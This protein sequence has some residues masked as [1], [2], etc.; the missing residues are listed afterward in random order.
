M[1]PGIDV[2]HWQSDIDWKKVAEAGVKFA[3][4]KASEFPDK[5]IKMYED[6]RFKANRQGAI[7]NGILW[8]AYHF[9]RTHIDP[10]HQA[11]SFCNVV[12]EVSSLPLVL[13]LEVAGCKGT[14]LVRKVKSFIDTAYNISGRKPI[15][16]TSGGFWRP[17]MTYEN[18]SDVDWAAEFP[19]WIA[20]Y[21]SQWPGTIYPWGGWD[22]W[23]YSDHGRLPG[24]KTNVD[25]N[26]FMGSMDDLRVRFLPE[27]NLPPE[28]SE[29]EPEM[30]EIGGPPEKPTENG[31]EIEEN[32]TS[33]A[34]NPN[35][36]EPATVPGTNEPEEEE[37]PPPQTSVP[38]TNKNI[39]CL[40]SLFEMIFSKK[41]AKKADPEQSREWIEEVVYQNQDK[42]KR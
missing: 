16:Y 14:K 42:K 38:N 19:L 22:F 32:E 40:Q 23:Q 31:E 6:E 28:E 1:I 9:F 18:I 29:E 30:I 27:G 17:F 20:R 13:D 7:D 24:I 39:P 21:T 41:N 8:G 25:L 15:I 33:P 36:E 37:T 34:E 3:F 12:G 10:V 4:I 5:K 11:E 26:W 2:S 35:G